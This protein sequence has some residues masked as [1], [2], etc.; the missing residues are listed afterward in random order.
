MLTYSCPVASD[1]NPI[2]DREAVRDHL[3]TVT[4]YAASIVGKE[5]HQSGKTHYH[6]Y[7]K[8]DP[9]CDST[10]SRVFDVAGV[11]PNIT[12]GMKWQ[13][14]VKYVTKQDKEAL[15]DNF[16]MSSLLTSKQ[17]AEADARV[18]SEALALAKQGKL[19][20]ATEHWMENAEQDWMKNFRNNEAVLDHAAR[21]YAGNRRQKPVHE[22]WITEHQHIDLNEL[23]PGENYKRTHVLVGPAGIGK[24]QLAKYLLKKAGCEQAVVV[25]N[26]E[27]VNQ[28]PFADGFVFDELAVNVPGK[29]FWEREAQVAV[30]DQDEDS[31]LKAR[32]KNAGLNW[33]C[34][35]IIT[36]NVLTRALMIEDEAIARRITVHVLTDKLF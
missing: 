12:H 16:V 19:K 32:Y 18:K 6:A 25:R 14:M 24:T 30:V 33:D 35:R 3:R 15:M 34:L 1:D 36:T 10:N 8:F 5:L 28:H 17:Q 2:P 4:H 7:V 23:R 21:H 11:H 9:K 31:V 22:T 20:Q 29:D 13:D 27:Q 26:H